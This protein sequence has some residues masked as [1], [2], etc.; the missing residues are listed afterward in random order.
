MIQLACFAVLWLIKSFSITSILFPL[1]LVVMIGVRKSLDYIF[2]KRELKIL[3]D[4]M[5]EMTK[6][7]RA[8]DLHQLEDGTKLNSRWFCT[9]LKLEPV[10]LE[11]RASALK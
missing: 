11:V 2:T 8:D 3:D 5:P 6:R 9:V 4:I 1:M 10:L 7:A